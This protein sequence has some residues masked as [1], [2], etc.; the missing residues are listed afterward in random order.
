[1]SVPGRPLADLVL[2][3]AD[4]LLVDLVVLL[5]LPAAAGPREYDFDV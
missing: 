1:V 2:R 4:E 3:E 5:D